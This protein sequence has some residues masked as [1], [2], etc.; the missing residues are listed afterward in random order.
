MGQQQL[1]LLVLGIVIVGIAAVAGMNSFAEGK[2]KA[3]RNAAT[4][5]AMRIVSGVQSWKLKPASSGGGAGAE[6]F[7]GVSFTAIG[8]NASNLQDGKYPTSTACMG[9]EGGETAVVTVF[10][11]DCETQIATVTVTG[12]EESDL[13]WAYADAD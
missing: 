2:N 13:T 3:N 8:I 12:M 4:N 1:L 10:E 7:D 11:Q 5:D 9:L 6:N